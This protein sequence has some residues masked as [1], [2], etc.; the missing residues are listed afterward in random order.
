MPSAGVYKK[1]VDLSLYTEIA[2]DLKLGIVHTFSK[3]PINERTLITNLASLEAVFGR[4]IDHDTHSQGFFALREFFRNANQAYVVRVESAANPAVAGMAGLRGGTDD[5]VVTG[6]DGVTSAAATRTLTSAGGDFVNDG[7]LV[8]DILEVHG[9]GADDGFYVLTTV[10]ATVLTVDRDWPTGS[11]TDQEFTVWSSKRQSQSDGATSVP[12]SRTFTSAL[13]DFTGMGVSVGDILYIHD[14]TDTEDNGFYVI[15]AVSA[16][17]LRVNREFPVGSKTGLT[18]TVYG[19]NHPAA[20]D[21]S[22]AAAGEFTSASA[23]FQAHG[24]KAGD[25]LIIDD[26]TDSGDNGTYV[27]TGLKESAE[28]TTLLVNAGEWPVGSL[29]GLSFKVV[30]SPVTFTAES[31]G[32]WA[33]GYAI[34]SVPHAV[35]PSL[36]NLNIYDANGFLVEQLVGLDTSNIEDEMDENSAYFSAEVISGRLGPAATSTAQV[37]GTNDGTTGLV[38]ADFIGTGSNALQAFKNVDEVE[39]DVL[40]I[41]GYSS[42][43]IGDA[44]INMAE[45]TR[46]DCM[47]ILDPPDTGTVADA[48]DVVDFHNGVNSLGR[49]TALNSSFGALYWPWVKVYDPYHDTDRY[50]APSGHAASVWAQSQNLTKPW[51]AAAG[52]KRGKVKGA[53]D[54]RDV[55]LDQGTRD[56]LQVGANV[57]PIVK[58]VREGI[59]VFGQK[60]LL[61]ASSALNRVNVRRMMLYLQRNILSA[62][63]Y[64]TFD[65]NDAT[66]DRELVRLITPLL[67]FVRD[68]RGLREFLVVVDDTTSP[69]IVRANNKLIGKIFIKPTTTAEVIEMQFILT[70]QD[71]SFQELLAA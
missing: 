41:P 56:F 31:A 11:L 25:L 6:A 30:P 20:E 33:E 40:I 51:F 36:V 59:H 61:R 1:E 24:V 10:A 2:S 50:T 45:S 26:A 17:T 3:G 43:N 15:E 54:I 64:V 13:G 37:N 68:H 28:E 9:G 62:V 23:K 48:Q 67:E 27:I 42:Q 55:L 14:D 49:T 58:F 12:S 4:P 7:V 18:Y 21:G 57:N 69:P 34:K 47:A 60:T 35:D 32:S 63:K 70:A 71:A 65:P 8:G 5:I 38:D 53:S 22:T 19:P 46:G 16:T 52:L 39:V 44:L 66:T 29:T